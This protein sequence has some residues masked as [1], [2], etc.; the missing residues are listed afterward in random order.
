MHVP[1]LFSL[2]QW[3]VLSVHLNMHLKNFQP[4]WIVGHVDQLRI[5]EVYCGCYIIQI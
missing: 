5:T 3:M 1:Q 2:V 4:F